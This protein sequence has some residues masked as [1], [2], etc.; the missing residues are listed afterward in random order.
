MSTRVLLVDDRET[1]RR[2]VR[3]LLERESGIEIVAEAGDGR[4]AVALVSKHRPA[5]VVMAIGL[6]DLNGIEAT[7]QI[8]G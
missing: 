1:T 2:G 3:S 7:R 5:M 4:T 8:R 6:P